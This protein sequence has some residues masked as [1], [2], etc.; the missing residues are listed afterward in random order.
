MSE[1]K[2][3]LTRVI[4]RLGRNPEA[5]FPDGADDYGYV[6]MA[7][8][9]DNRLDADVWRANREACTV[10]RFHPNETAADGW[11]RLRGENWYFWYDEADEGPEEPVF[12][13]GSHELRPGEYVTVREGDGDVLTFRV[14]EAVRL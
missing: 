9:V 14:A 12:K 2:K 11:L 7:P 5:G 13:L 8:L 1:Q 4:L 10:R 3:H 6:L